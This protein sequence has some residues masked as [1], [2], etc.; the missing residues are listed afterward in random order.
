MV[1]D[2]G[3]FPVTDGDVCGDGRPT[4]DNVFGAEA[5]K[6]AARTAGLAA[7]RALLA[8]GRERREGADCTG[9]AA[10]QRLQGEHC[11]QG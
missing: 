6:G 10:L 3:G 5:P 1:R 4:P 9:L 11:R 8:A 7:D 2:Q